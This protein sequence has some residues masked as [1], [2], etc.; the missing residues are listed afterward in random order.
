M[1]R[2]EVI[3][4]LFDLVDETSMIISSELKMSYLHAMCESCENIMSQEISQS[5]SEESRETLQ[6][7]YAVLEGV[8]VYT[9][10]NKKSA[11]VSDFERTKIR[12]FNKCNY[13]T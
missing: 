6:Q 13:D 1:L 11:S 3:E 12:T 9:R 5:M 10:G 4:Q 7:Q 8:R 2:P